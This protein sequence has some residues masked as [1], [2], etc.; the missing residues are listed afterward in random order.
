VAP[1]DCNAN[2]VFELAGQFAAATDK[3]HGRHDSFVVH[4]GE[5]EHGRC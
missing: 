2:W 5:G 4:C 1:I 3:R